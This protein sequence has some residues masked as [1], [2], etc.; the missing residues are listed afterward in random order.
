VVA[1]VEGKILRFEPRA[2]LYVIHRLD[3]H[4]AATRLARLASEGRALPY[5]ELSELASEAGVVP[6][7]SETAA[8]RALEPYGERLLAWS[9]RRL[10]DRCRE[11]GIVPMMAYL[12]I[13]TPQPQ[14]LPVARLLAIARGAGF[15]TIDLTGVYDGHPA[16]QLT[17]AA[18]DD[19]PNAAGHRLVADRLYAALR[20]M[21]SV[22]WGKNDAGRDQAAGAQLHSEGVPAR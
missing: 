7:A 6:G 21:E 3:A 16:D 8:G 2:L 13:L 22:L 1:A 20:G 14:D 17:I 12:P 15:T 11:R 10:F 4:N 19:H 18:W 9:Y 5:P